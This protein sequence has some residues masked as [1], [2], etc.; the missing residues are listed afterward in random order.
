MAGADVLPEVVRSKLLRRADWRFLLPNPKPARSTCFAGGLLAE[1]VGLISEHVA[2][3]RLAPPGECD[4]AV[5]VNPGRATLSAAR[6]ALRPGGSCYTEWYSPLAGGSGGVRRRLEAAGFEAVT[7]YWAWPSPSRPQLWL[8]LDAP[9]ARRYFLTSRPAARGIVGRGARAVRQALWLLSLRAHVTFPVCATARKPVGPFDGRPSTGRPKLGAARGSPNASAPGGD[10]ARTI[11]A[12]WGGW[13]LGPTPD[14]LSWLVLAVGERSISK[15]VGLVF[16]EPDPRPRLAVKLPR[17]PEAV[18]ALTREATTLRAVQ[19]LRPG[20]VQGVPRV[21]FCREHAGVLTLGETALPGLPIF[22]QLRRDNYRHLALAATAWLANLAG[23]SDPRP[24]T[25]WWDRLVEPVL[26]A[27][28]ESFGSVLDPG[29]LRETEGMLA[30]LGDLPIVCEHRDFSPWNV[31]VTADGGLAVL[32]WESG[33]LR[34]LPALDLIYFLS[35]LGFFLDGALASGRCR[36]SYRASLNPSTLTGAVMAESLARYAGQVGLDPAGLRP[37]RLLVWL[38][39]SRSEYRR[40][41]DDVAGRPSPEALR[42]SLFVGLW[43]EE[44]RQ[45]TGISYRAQPRLIVRCRSSE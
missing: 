8:S 28:Q 10:L 12:G 4:L 13:G 40:L 31:L 34:G 27:F 23:R 32:D 44:L 39:H 36:E 37:L 5:A 33:E 6:A 21:L 24:R 7:C 45:A 42:R 2:D 29:L 38:L 41:V 43:E 11:R 25:A 26:T 19:A 30:T 20:G 14:S 15:L 18:S 35:Y 17:V 16:A 1:A 9:G 22:T 3:A